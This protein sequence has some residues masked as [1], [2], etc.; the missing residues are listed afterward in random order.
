V[1]EGHSDNVG[2]SEFN[3]K[4][5]QQRAD[6]VVSYLVNDLKIASSRLSAVAYGET[7]PI[8]DNST[9]EGQQANRRIDAVIACATDIA[10]LKVVP[11]RLTMAL[12]IEFDPYKSDVNSQYF[13]ELGEVARFMKANPRVNAIVEAHTGKYLGE[14][15]DRVKVDPAIA[16][17]VSMLRAEKIVDYL[18]E[19]QGVSRSRL[20]ASAFGQTSRA[21][22]GTTLEGQQ[23]NRR[24]NIIYTYPK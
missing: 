13:S 4:L 1:I 7:R 3:M 16:M 14:G 19:K 15:A 20:S 9:R 8:A 17:K 23:E 5:S 12:E 6:S 2:T 22:Y 21:A 10:G 24:V 18:V 11:A